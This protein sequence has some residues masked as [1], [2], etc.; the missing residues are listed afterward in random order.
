MLVAAV[1][2]VLRR[3]GYDDGGGV[4]TLDDERVGRA[5]QAIPGL[6]ECGWDVLVVGGGILYRLLAL[7]PP[8]CWSV[9]LDGRGM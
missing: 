9:R 3:C 8:K 5:G 7:R 4:V 2:Y 6:G 1:E